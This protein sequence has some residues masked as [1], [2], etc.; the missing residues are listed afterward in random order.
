MRSA[1]AVGHVKTPLVAG[2]LRVG[3]MSWAGQNS[4]KI[5]TTETSAGAWSVY[6]DYDTNSEVV[7]E[8]RART[9]MGLT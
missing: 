1:C 3:Q 5:P 2:N 7:I 4:R 9:G 8:M 6:A